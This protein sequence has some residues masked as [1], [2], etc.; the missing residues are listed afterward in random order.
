M[1]PCLRG[2]DWSRAGVG[3]D[4]EQITRGFVDA[5][6]RDEP[7]LV[8]RSPGHRSLGRALRG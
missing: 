1:P 6:L 8:R 2:F 4:D 5:G 3:W 7:N